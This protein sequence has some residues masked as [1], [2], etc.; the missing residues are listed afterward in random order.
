MS[1]FNINQYKSKGVVPGNPVFIGEKKQ[2]N[3]KIRLIA[4]N[5]SSYE[6]V[7][8]ES[9][10]E[11]S[12]Y[13]SKFKNLWINID[14]L[15]D[16]QT[17]K[18]VGSLFNIHTL[19][20]EDIAHTGQHSKV[21]INDGYIFSIV[22]MMGFDHSDYKLS[23]EQVSMYL[24]KDVLI[25]FQEKEGDVF[26]PIRERIRHEK[27]RIRSNG[28]TYLKYSLLDTIVDNYIFLM[29][30]FA[31]NVEEL[32]DKILLQ[33]NKSTLSEINTNKIE[34]NYFRRIVRPTKEAIVNFKTTKSALIT[35]KEQP[36]FNDLVDLTQRS[37]DTID[38]Y[39]N[40]LSEQLIIYSTN[41]NNRLNDI[42]KILTIFSVIFTP[43]T[44]IV[45][46]YGTNFE[47]IPELKYQY[48]YQLMWGIIV[49]VVL[50][51]I[52]FFRKKRWF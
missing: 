38:S 23:A 42:I 48:G 6:E 10:Y 8:L 27:G 40:M 45:G 19:I 22:K 32:E 17:I 52:L 25:T 51:M 2:K 41:V 11:I 26:E 50:L 46:V 30:I 16:I 33:P 5:E 37:F 3:I 1:R 4:Y 49:L 18:D 34:L 15:H 29:E 9:V 39:K 13:A 20:L 44:F 31:D 28:L 21:E 24:T 47:H 43:I 7:T 12:A 36:F 35:R 14:G